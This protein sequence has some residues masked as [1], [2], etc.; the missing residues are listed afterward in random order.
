MEI[1]SFVLTIVGFGLSISAYF[2]ATSVESA[3]TA[4]ITRR[5]EQLDRDRLLA[6]LAKLNA[7]KEAAKRRRD[8]APSAMTSG[9]SLEV[10]LHLL[11]EADDALKTSLPLK[12]ENTLAYDLSGASEE[13]SQ[14]VATIAQPGANRDGWK[15]ALSTLQIIIPRLEQVEREVSNKEL[16]IIRK[17]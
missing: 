3:V 6:L 7:A 5:N 16:H 13:I 15:D 4:V 17:I 12:L 10:D 1:F 9:H 2:K 8:G 14:A 11:H